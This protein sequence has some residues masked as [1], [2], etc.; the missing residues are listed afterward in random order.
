MA[1]PVAERVPTPNPKADGRCGADLHGA[2]RNRLEM[3]L[4]AAGVL[5][6]DTTDDRAAVAAALSTMVDTLVAEHLKGLSK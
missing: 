2:R 5:D 4:V 6:P 1:T 3:L